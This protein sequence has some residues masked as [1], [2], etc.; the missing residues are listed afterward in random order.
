MVSLLPITLRGNLEMQ[1][2]IN[3]KNEWKRIDKQMFRKTK[4][5]NNGLFFVEIPD[6]NSG[7]IYMEA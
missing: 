1:E 2:I 6:L 3:R 7:K 4:T 5:D